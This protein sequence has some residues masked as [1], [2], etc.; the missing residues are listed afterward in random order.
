M[1]VYIYS[2]L[3]NKLEMWWLYLSPIEIKCK[4]LNSHSKYRAIVINHQTS[5]L[6]VNTQI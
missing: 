2:Y 4:Q 3:V 1:Y 6:V 5:H